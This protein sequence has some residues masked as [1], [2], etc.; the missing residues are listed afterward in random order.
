MTTTFE[1]RNAQ[2]LVRLIAEYPLA[3]VVSKNDSG[4]GNDSGFGATPLPLLG[5]T[6]AQ[7]RIVSLLGHFA[8]SNPHVTMLR[9]SPQATILF[10]GPHGYISPEAVSRPGWAPTWNYAIAQFDVDIE[11]L[12]QENDTALE[13]LVTKMEADRREPWTIS[14]MGE[15]YAKMAQRILAF[16]GHVRTAR[17]RFKL[18]QDETPQTLAE[19]L[20][21]VND[22]ALVR[23]MKDFNGVGDGSKES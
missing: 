1:P 20:T 23:W 9:A 16:R 6:D 22:A 19:I 17:G 12:P 18:G 2:D 7:G 13:R 15:R 10:T 4:S 8:L 5:E 21:E 3:W 11:F 14:R